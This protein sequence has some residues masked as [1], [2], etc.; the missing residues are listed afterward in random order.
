MKKLRL[1]LTARAA[2]ICA[3]GVLILIVMAAVYGLSVVGLALLRVDSLQV[4]AFGIVVIAV[5]LGISVAGVLELSER[6]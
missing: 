3:A 1:I 6:L 4:E 5:A 2:E